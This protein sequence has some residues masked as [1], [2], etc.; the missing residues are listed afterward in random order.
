MHIVAMAYFLTIICTNAI[1][2]ILNKFKYLL[3]EKTFYGKMITLLS[4]DI[5]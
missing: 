3:I 4:V 5:I 2:N 1:E